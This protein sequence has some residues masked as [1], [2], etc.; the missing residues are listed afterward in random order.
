MVRWATAM[1]SGPSNSTPPTLPRRP[2]ASE[3]VLPE[4]GGESARLSRRIFS[5]LRKRA[6][7]GAAFPPVLLVFLSLLIYAN[8]L[9]NGFV[10]DDKI[11]IERNPLLRSADG[12]PRLFVTP[13][14]AGE[15]RF[16]RLYRPVTSTT[17]ALNYLAGKSDPWGFHLT[18][19]LLHGF[20]AVLLWALLVE[21][22]GFKSL[23]LFAALLFV[24]HP[25]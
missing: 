21:L 10:F 20:V 14:W 7:S 19:A 25:V 17:F 16:N 11:I 6:F 24:V 12:I 18:N 2:R 23:A 15:G 5:S 8:S 4:P 13:Y 3:R 9:P 22:F 1:E